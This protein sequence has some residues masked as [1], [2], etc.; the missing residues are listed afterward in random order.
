MNRKVKCNGCGY[1]GDESE[2]PKGRDFFQN[3]FISGCPKCNNCQSPGGASLRM[4]PGQ[5]H[6]FE[7]VKTIGKSDNPAIRVFQDANEA[8]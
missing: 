8:S 4:M 3:Q 2:F 7:F 5:K 1:I 6:P